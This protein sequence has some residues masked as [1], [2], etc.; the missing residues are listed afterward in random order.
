MDRPDGWMWGPGGAFHAREG[1]ASLDGAGGTMPY[2][3][4]AIPYAQPA[5]SYAQP[6]ISYAQTA[7]P[8]EQPAIPYARVRYPIRTRR[9]HSTHVIRPVGECGE[10]SRSLCAYRGA[11]RESNARCR[12]T[13]SG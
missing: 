8:Y 1:S 9:Y 2:A 7:I 10:G 11:E 13:E 3:L 5:I 6:A 4:S 12:G